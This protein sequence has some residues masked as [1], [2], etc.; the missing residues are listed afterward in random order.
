MA[1][2][3]GRGGRTPVPPRLRRTLRRH[4]R[5]RAVRVGVPG[6]PP[7]V[8]ALSD[9]E[10]K[11][12][13]ARRAVVAY[14]WRAAEC[15]DISETPFTNTSPSGGSTSPPRRVRGDRGRLLR[16]GGCNPGRRRSAT[17]PRK[18]DGGGGLYRF[19][20]LDGGFTADLPVDADGL[21][22][23]YPELFKRVFP[24]RDFRDTY[25]L[26][27]WVNRGQLERHR[28]GALG[29]EE[30]NRGTTSSCPALGSAS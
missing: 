11:W 25:L 20:S 21:V 27:R 30:E 15:V 19:L 2:L 28:G 6:E 1:W 17:P 5:V 3:L 9:G 13:G 4:W 12:A 8:E 26:G 22:L 10:G 23:D 7:R 16:W 29:R 14:T 18:V 24:R